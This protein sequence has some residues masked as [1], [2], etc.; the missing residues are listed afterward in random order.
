[1][2]K[3]NFLPHG[4]VTGIGSLPFQQGAQAVQFV[5]RH[6][7]HLPFVPELP[8]RTADEESIGRVLAPVSTLLTRQNA[9][10][11]DIAT[12][13]IDRFLNRLETAPAEI[14]PSHGAA[15]PLFE[16]ALTSGAF[17]NAQAVKIQLVGP[18]TLAYS[19]FYEGQSLACDPTLGTALTEYL[20]RLAREQI[21][22]LSGYG[23]PVL[24]FLDEPCLYF[25][26]RLPGGAETMALLSRIIDTLHHTAPVL[27]G[28]HS[29]AHSVLKALLALD[30]DIVSFDA[31]TELET[32]LAL[33]ETRAFLNGGGIA[34]LGWVPT[35]SDLNAFDPANEFTRLVLTL[36]ELT[37]L[38]QLAQ[39][40]LITATCGLGLL[41]PEA[42][43]ESFAA[44]Q[45]FKGLFQRVTL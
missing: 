22:R 28:V 3:F 40:T 1:M 13:K 25:H 17:A 16:R 6:S 34:A 4:L 23:L 32:F 10:R 15:L 30:L 38:E 29:C 19:L 27:I 14:P 12:G 39:Q 33:P 42:A 11:F 8:Q 43:Q 21:E 5:Q 45:R 31:H 24:L 44:A 7:P 9:G 35:W 41:T 2:T 37:L 36:P 18:M 20:L 26:D